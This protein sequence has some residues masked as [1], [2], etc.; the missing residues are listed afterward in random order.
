MKIKI[1]FLLLF[2]IS[3]SAFSQINSYNI[4]QT[5]IGLGALPLDLDDD[6]SNDFLFDI[7]LLPSNALAARVTTMGF[8]QMLDNSTFGYPNTL[9]MGSPVAGFFRSGIGVLG[10][11][12]NA[13]QFNGAGDKYLGIKINASGNEYFGWIKLNCSLGRDTL[14]IISC[15]YNTVASD[16][17]NAGQVLATGIN[18]SAPT[19]NNVFRAYPNPFSAFTVLQTNI[20]LNNATLTIENCLGQRVRQIENIHEKTIVIERD[21]LSSGLYFA[22]LTQ[23]NQIIATVKLIITD[24]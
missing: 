15:G 23:N 20:Q 4:N 21:K 11:F 7:I 13:G 18:E 17:I 1:I 8:S 22:H 3:F 14:K 19:L 5:I 9:N 2:T 24:N 10:T 16:A 6:G 12:N